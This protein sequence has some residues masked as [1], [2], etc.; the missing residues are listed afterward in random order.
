MATCDWVFEHARRT[1]DAPAV[2]SPDDRLSYGVLAGRVLGAASTLWRMGV[3]A[4]DRVVVALPNVPAAVVVSLAVQHLDAVSVEVSREWTADQL[5]AVLREVAPS[6]VALAGQDAPKLGAVLRAA[7][8]P[9]LVLVQVEPTREA[10][11]SPGDVETIAMTPGGV[12]D[13]AAIGELPAGPPARDERAVTLLLYTSG[14]TGQP[15]AVMQTLTNIAANTR[16]IAEVLGLGAKDRAM[17][18]LPL[19]YCYGRSVLQTHLYVG[20]SVFLYPGFVYPRLV[21]EAIAAERCTG[22]AGVPLTYELLARHTEPRPGDM[23]GLRYVTQAGGA[24]RSATI[25]WT[26][27]V[28]RPAPL[29][30]MYGQTEATARLAYLPPERGHEKRGSIG[31]PIPGVELRV[32][33]DLGTDVACGVT[34]H[35]VARGANV[36]PGYYGAPE[37]TASILRDGWL[38]TGDMAYRDEDGFL[39]LAGRAKEILKIGGHRGSPAQIEAALEQH[40]DVMEVVAAGIADP[41]R[42][43]AAAALAVLRPGALATEQELRRFCTQH[44]PPY[45]VPRV[46]RIVGSMPRGPSGKIQRDRVS[47]LLA[48]VAAGSPRQVARAGS[49][50]RKA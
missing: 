39:F 37:E 48:R 38:W 27:A 11:E 18:I 40:P 33:D 28:F 50:E 31:I 7:R 21:L 29:F 15:R 10:S 8:I 6:A 35:L 22:F 4:G 1:P 26:R 17:L 23:P 44:L 47:R 36:T 3:R 13:D 30:V 12:L 45:L 32:V 46:V 14:S 34:G 9:R 19:P 25:D 41:L 42:G 16:A 5:S 2:D 49:D 24:M 20:G 43:E